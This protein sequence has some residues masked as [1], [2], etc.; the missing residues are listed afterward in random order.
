[1][2]ILISAC[3]LGVACRYDQKSRPL[4]EKLLE[5][6][7]EVHRLIP[8]CPEVY[9]GLPTPR[10]PA[11]ISKGRVINAEGRDVTAE[12]KRGAE[13]ALRLAKLFG[14][15]VAILKEK[16]PSCGAG[17]IY[18]GSF[19]RTLIEGDGMTARLLA[20]AGIRVYC[21]SEIEELL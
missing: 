15:E 17:R 7:A 5:R 16:S 11:E 20:A 14:C 9:G 10:P 12:Y 8:I 3:L 13:E 1:M 2:N 4:D 18:D 6:L 21:E 19:T